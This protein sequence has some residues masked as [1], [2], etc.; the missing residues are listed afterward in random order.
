MPT[1][2]TTTKFASKVRRRSPFDLSIERRSPGVVCNPTL[3]MAVNRKTNTSI[4]ESKSNSIRNMVSL[5]CLLLRRSTQG[6]GPEDYAPERQ[7][8]K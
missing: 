1:M 7:E 8:A 2:G 5:F 4:L 6:S 3:S